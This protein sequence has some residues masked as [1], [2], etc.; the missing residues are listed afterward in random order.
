MAKFRGSPLS[1]LRQTV[2]VNKFW[3]VPMNKGTEGQ[4]ILKTGKG[5][6]E[7]SCNLKQNP[8]SQDMLAATCHSKRCAVLACWKEYVFYATHHIS[9]I[10]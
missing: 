9:T 2:V 6:A 3:A 5:K 10:N 1:H 8:N 7:L 4:A